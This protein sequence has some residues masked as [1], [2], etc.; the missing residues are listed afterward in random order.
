MA[1][2]TP[3]A[4]QSLSE[5]EPV[6]RSPVLSINYDRFFSRSALGKELV[7]ELEAER[8]LL[9]AENRRIEA[10]LEA[11]EI[12]LTKARETMPADEFRAAAQAFDEKVQNIRDERRQ[13]ALELT[14]KGDT[15]R[16]QFD[17]AALPVLTRIVRDAG[18]A[19]VVDTR[20]VVL[21]LDAIDIT[22]LAIARLDAAQST[23][24]DDA[25][26]NAPDDAADP[27]PIDP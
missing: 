13:L 1:L 10:E 15:V 6:I 24:L 16:Q 19:V 7:A 23:E 9:E 11:E 5:G 4:A 3:L 21:T 25:E 20:S 27:E 14:E 8:I 2:A 22:D 18:A 12:E 26:E 17:E